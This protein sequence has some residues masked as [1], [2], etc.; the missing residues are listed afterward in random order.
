MGMPQSFEYDDLFCLSC[1]ITL[2]GVHPQYQDSI[3]HICPLQ[4]EPIPQSE[5]SGPLSRMITY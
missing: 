1:R 5:H 2:L 3:D 4:R